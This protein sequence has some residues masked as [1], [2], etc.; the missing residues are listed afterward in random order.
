MVGWP[1]QVEIKRPMGKR[2]KKRMHCDAGGGGG[3]DA[4]K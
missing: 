1:A 4:Q 3:G 2:K